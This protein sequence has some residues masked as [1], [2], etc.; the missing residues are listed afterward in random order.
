[1]GF[2]TVP[3]QCPLSATQG[4]STGQKSELVLA[5]KSLDP[6][7]TKSMN[8][9]R[10]VSQRAL[11]KHSFNPQHNKAL[12]KETRNTR[13]I[14]SAGKMRQKCHLYQAAL[15]AWKKE[16]RTGGNVTMLGA[17]HSVEFSFRSLQ[18]SAVLSHIPLNSAFYF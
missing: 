15:T 16:I 5:I 7:R 12:G 8:F 6:V 9:L 4:C 3:R 11:V 1:M 18:G 17:L 10:C 14:A 13:S 2:Y